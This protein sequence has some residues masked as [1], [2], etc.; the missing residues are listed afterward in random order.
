MRQNH[1]VTGNAYVLR[2]GMRVVSRTD[3][4]G[5]ITLVNADFIEASG[6]SES[7]LIGAPQ[8]LLRHP[9]MPEAV[10]KDLWETVQQ[11]KPWSGLLKNRR[12]NGDHFWVRAHI[13]PRVENGVAVGY[14]SI[15]ALPD[16]ADVQLFDAFYRDLRAGRAGGGRLAAGR[17]LRGGPRGLMDRLHH[18]SLR[19]RLSLVTA[20]AGLALALIGSMGIFGMHRASQKVESVRAEVLEPSRLANQI[21][22]LLADSRGHVLLG[23]QHNPGLSIS[24][25]HDH[26]LSLHLD[27]ITKNTQQIT[28]NWQRLSAIVFNPA[29]PATVALTD[30]M[31]QFQEARMTFGMDGILPAKAAL[32]AEMYHEAAVILLFNINPLYHALNRATDELQS[33]LD[34]YAA[35]SRELAETRYVWMRN[36]II[37]LFLFCLVGAV[38]MGWLLMRSVVR[39]LTR[40]IGYFE[41]ISQGRYDNRIVIE[42]HD[43]IGRVLDA[44]AFMQSRL[45]YE[46]TESHRVA[47]ASLRVKIALDNVSAPVMMADNTRTIVY[48]NKAVM[49]MFKAAEADIRTQLPRFSA[50]H[51]LGANIDQF[52]KQPGHQ[53]GLLA[54]LRDT[55]RS[56]LTI[57]G[58]TMNV[59][60][61][62]VIDT[63]GERHGAVV[64]WSDRTPEVAVEK[65]IAGLVEAAAAGDLSRRLGLSGKDGFFLQLAEGINRL[66]ETTERGVND[67]A[68]VL[69]GLSQGDLTQRMRG[70]YQG[71][72]GQLQDD[73]NATSERLAEIVAQIREATDAIHTASREIASGN[74]DLSSRTE[75]QASSLEETASSM[76]EFT[77]T[78]KQNADNARQANQLAH[79]ASEIAAKGGAVVD[80]VVHTMGAIAASS[81]K[82]ADI[83][84]VI[85]GI[86]FQTN[87]L[88]LNAAV[89]AA[90]AGEQGRGFAVVAGEVRNLAQRSAA[91]AKEIKGLI[92]DSVDKVSDGY[93]QVEQAGNT[94]DEV[95]G[96]VKRVTDIMGEIS[97]ASLEQ[98]QGIE[99]VNRAI[100]QMDETTQQNAALVEQAAAAAESMQEQAQSLAEAVSLFKM[101]GGMGALAARGNA[102]PAAPRVSQPG[103][104]R[105]MRR[106]APGNAAQDEWAEF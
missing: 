34:V 88:A 95:V 1:P 59:V 73:A 23:L 77:S 30:K 38:V 10:F 32:E 56:T 37:G 93:K 89:E 51:L 8:N 4:Q 101:A 62:P 6:Y 14:E 5:V 80:Q 75:S 11:G 105:A 9:D 90:R 63:Q 20:M 15:Q 57:G 91:A 87:I 65:E 82:I 92:S 43:E 28:E 69:Q 40:T 18:L 48:A 55:Y 79:G 26:P 106:L 42:R 50:D 67:V 31:A 24:G 99:Q 27:V 19:A 53:A 44:L 78:V 16:E 39:P 97:A 36:G 96:A 25:L 58:R 33:A 102:A 66:V 3:T 74:A 71:L 103:P 68:T 70:D 41:R 52:H 84:G 76:D 81:K 45:G 22:Y 100:A 54:Q 2:E 98:S 83:I 21:R 35:E 94:M 47:Q 61:N 60:A 49:S 104:V 7:E 86:A 64:E 29:L 46:V 85:D 72:F 13:S 12:K 17:M